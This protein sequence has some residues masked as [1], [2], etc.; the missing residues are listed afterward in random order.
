M[1]KTPWL[2]WYPADWR[3]ETTLRMVGREARSLWID[4]IGV[5]HE[6]E[7]Y[8]HLLI[9]GL[10]PTLK[11]LS[12]IFGD[13]PDKIAS[14]LHELQTANVFSV[15][16]QGVIYSRRMVEDRQ[17]SQVLSEAGKAGGSPLL[18][19][20]VKPS[21][22]RVP[23]ARDQ[24]PDTRSQKDNSVASQ[25]APEAPGTPLDLKRELWARGIPFLQKAGGLNERSARNL[26]GKWRR[27][28]GDVEVINALAAAEGAAASEPAAYVQR[29]LNGKEKANGSGQHG[30]TTHPLGV[31]G[32]LADDARAAAIGAHWPPGDD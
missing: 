3:A 15:N 22:A 16:E 6:A 29:V 20:E 32:Q 1:A 13:E 24:K 10:K 9:G 19:G 31:F 5:M 28:H 23:E 7:P 11:Q 14:L 12:Q 4:I 8:G 30:K 26:L 21:R 2:K 25:R 18:K 17:K 27:D